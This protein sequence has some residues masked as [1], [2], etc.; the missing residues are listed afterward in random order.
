MIGL[1]WFRK[2]VQGRYGFDHLS[3]ALIILYW[4]LFLVYNL[5]GVLIFNYLAFVCIFLAIFRFLS[6]NIARRQA[7]N[8]KFHQLFKPVTQWFSLTLRK[9]RERNTHRFYKCA[10]CGQILRVPV[11]KGNITIRCKKCGA[12]I[13]AKT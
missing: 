10:G 1:N 13:K 3:Y 12:S 7:E 8:R 11:G 4:P 9:V 6:K 5:T 2:F